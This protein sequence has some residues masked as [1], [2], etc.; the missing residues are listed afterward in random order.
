MEAG[1]GPVRHVP[2]VLAQ[3]RQASD[4]RRRGV[5]QDRCHRFTPHA[6][7][8]GSSVLDTEKHSHQHRHPLPRQAPQGHRARSREPLAARQALVRVRPRAWARAP[9]PLHC[10]LCRGYRSTRRRPQRSRGGRWRGRSY[11]RTL[12]L[13]TRRVCRM[14]LRSLLPR[15]MRLPCRRLLRRRCRMHMLRSTYAMCL[16]R[17]HIRSSDLRPLPAK[18]S[19]LSPQGRCR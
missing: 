3:E 19:I 16:C 4:G 13:R 1:Q 18:S 9:D 11:M 10:T 12:S 7:G 14:L 5:Q 17:R 2:H 6:G 15:R 8:G